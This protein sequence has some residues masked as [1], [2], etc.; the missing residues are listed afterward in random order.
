MM[1]TD[2]GGETLFCC[3]A[4]AGGGVPFVGILTIFSLGENK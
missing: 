4:D 3:N 2:P 1:D